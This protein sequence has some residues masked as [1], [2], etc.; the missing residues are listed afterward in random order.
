[1]QHRSATESPARLLHL[2]AVIAAITNDE[3]DV[4]EAFARAL[5]ESANGDGLIQ[6]VLATGKPSWIEDLGAD[7]TLAWSKQVAA[8]GLSSAI[9]VPV[10]VGAEIV[11]VLGFYSFDPRPPDPDLLE[12]LQ[13]VGVQLVRMIE[14]ARSLELLEAEHA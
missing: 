11:A 7:P 6:S 4:D 1:M 10:R 9:A 13:T 12:L 8:A 5:E 3:T 2:L 14:R